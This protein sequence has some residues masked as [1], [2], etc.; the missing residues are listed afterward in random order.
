MRY[1]LA[2]ALLLLAG[3]GTVGEVVQ[4]PSGWFS[5]GGNVGGSVQQQPLI[6]RPWA[7]M[8]PGLFLLGVLVSIGGSYFRLP[9]GRGL[10]GSL[11]VAGVASTVIAVAVSHAWAPL[12]GLIAVVGGLIWVAMEAYKRY[13]NT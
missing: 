1:A 12:V 6:V 8:G 4:G 3:C 5:S 7:L 10:A 11:V 2:I 9:G 13:K